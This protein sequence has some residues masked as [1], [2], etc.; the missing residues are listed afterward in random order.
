MTNYPFTSINDFNDIEA[1]NGYKADVLT[2]KTT[3]V[4]YLANLRPMQWDATPNGGFTTAAK[5][6]LAVNPNYREIN[7]QQ[8]LADP[9]SVY[10]YTQ[11]M[12]ALRQGNP[13]LVYGEYKDLDPQNSSIFVYTR[14]LEA[15]HYLVVLNFSHDPVTYPIPGGLKPTGLLIGNQPG[16]E[17]NTTTLHLKPWE[18]R[19]Y[20][21]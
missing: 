20:Q 7:A 17:V 6:W 8:E 3:E 18:A 5:P 1:R 15:K 12:I 19:I 14:V 11:H 16:S 2:H 9:N 4:D 21:Y 13:A 10:H